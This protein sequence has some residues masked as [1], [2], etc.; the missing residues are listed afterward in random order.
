MDKEDIVTEESNSSKIPPQIPTINSSS[1]LPS[2]PLDV[3][4]IERKGNV[5]VC[6]N[7]VQPC[8]PGIYSAHTLVKVVLMLSHRG[9][10]P[11]SGASINHF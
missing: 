5:F 6:T 9:G 3:L 8:S 11:A 1:L 7:K 4:F 2:Q 10:V